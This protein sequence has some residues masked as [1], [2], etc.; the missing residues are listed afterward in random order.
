MSDDNR[1]NYLFISSLRNY[2]VSSDIR[3]LFLIV[4][5]LYL[6]IW[7]NVLSF[8]RSYS[9]GSVS[10]AWVLTTY[11]NTMWMKWEYVCF[12]F[13]TPLPLHRVV[14]SSTTWICVEV[15][16]VG[17]AAASLACCGWCSVMLCVH[18]AR[19]VCLF[20]CWSRIIVLLNDLH[21]WVRTFIPRTYINYT[22]RTETKCLHCKYNNL[23]L[24][25]MQEHSDTILISN[26]NEYK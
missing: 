20:T 2:L 16:M 6:S 22:L 25:F 10:S 17:T 13:F 21:V 14:Y 8:G 15:C 9:R 19:Q 12:F 11:H 1:Y 4:E 24:F 5:P 26:E 18:I 7:S 23:N 3:C